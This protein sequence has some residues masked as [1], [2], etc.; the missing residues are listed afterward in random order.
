MAGYTHVLA[1]VDLGADSELLVARALAVAQRFEARLSLAHVVEYVLAEPAGETL[2]PPPMSLE[3]ELASGAE[4]QL[5]EFAARA[6]AGEADRHVAVGSIPAELSR[7]VEDLGV[8]LLI[9]GAH[10]RHWLAFFA[11]GTERS[12]LKRVACD[13]LVVRLP[14]SRDGEISS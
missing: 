3:P 2:L 11:S 14:K 1:A 9:A 10:E 12:L 6:G 8:D 13:V 4:L 7:L 5:A